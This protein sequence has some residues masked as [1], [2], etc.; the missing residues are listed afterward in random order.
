ML[1]PADSMG[2][3]E[4]QGRA[5]GT[6]NQPCCGMTGAGADGAK[7]EPWAM[8]R[9]GGSLECWAGTNRPGSACRA[10]TAE[11]LP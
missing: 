7:L 10:L 8:G 6:G 11:S 5:V 3:M 2:P 9:V 4:G 1:R